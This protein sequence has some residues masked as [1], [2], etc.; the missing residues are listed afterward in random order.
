M[1]VMTRLVLLLALPGALLTA[2]ELS[3]VRSVYLMPM[4]RGLDQYLAN[5]L[6]NEKVFQV[7]TDPSLA[8]AVFTDRI[9]QGFQL[10]LETFV[11]VAK[12]E[13]APAPAPKE[14]KATKNKDAQEQD[15][16]T[17]ITETVNKLDN[18]GLNSSFGRGKGTIFLV[19]M[20]S[21]QVIWSTYEP[22]PNS[23]GKEM[24]RASTDVVNRLMKDMGLQKKK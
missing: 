12:P 16:A 4:Y 11:P 19:D 23:V 22:A 5:R 7:V 24:D 17:L 1:D 3:A 6:T 8:D 15:R 9:G 2:A 10:Q 21:R 20:K 14:A 18:P 13:P